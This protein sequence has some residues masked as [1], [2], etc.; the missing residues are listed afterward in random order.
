MISLQVVFGLWPL[1]LGLRTRQGACRDNRSFC[2][3]LCALCLLGYLRPKETATET[4]R[5]CG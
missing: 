2:V 3:F 1:V 5:G 4:Q